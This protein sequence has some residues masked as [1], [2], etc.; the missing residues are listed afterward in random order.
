MK[1]NTFLNLYNIQPSDVAVILSKPQREE[2]R[3]QL[4]SKV[5]HAEMLNRKFASHQ[6]DKAS[7]T[8]ARR[9]YAL[10]FV[11]LRRGQYLLTGFYQVNGSEPKNANYFD[12]DE[13][14]CALREFSRYDIGEACRKNNSETPVVKLEQMEQCQAFVGRLIIS[15]DKKKGE[16]AF[17]RLAENLEAG[18]YAIR[19][20]NWDAE[21]APNWDE[22][23]VTAPIVRSL[24][25]A[26]E[27]RLKEWRGVYLIVDEESG[28]RYVGSAYGEY[29]FLNRWKAHVKGENIE[30]GDR[31]I[32]VQLR[33]LD[34]SNFRFSILQVVAPDTDN[35]EIIQIENMWMD[36]LHTRKH[37]LNHGT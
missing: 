3:I 8:L 14:F 1:L 10:L 16:M 33:K 36:R 22:F 4:I 19:E 5:Q 35:A 25:P 18:V 28:A 26:W 21:P 15:V 11:P 17:M 2:L 20:Q 37:G 27:A 29:G 23:I 7:K 31:G 6:S 34:P 9:K 13:G 30:G 12:Q 24:P 32:T